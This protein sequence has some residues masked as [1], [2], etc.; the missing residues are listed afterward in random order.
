MWPQVGVGSADGGR[1]QGSPAS[2]STEP[3]AAPAAA[4]AARASAPLGLSAGRAPHRVLWHR[5]RARIRLLYRVRLL[6]AW[7]GDGGVGVAARR[8]DDALGLLRAHAR[9][10]A[11]GAVSNPPSRRQ[12]RR[13]RSP[14][15]AAATFQVAAALASPAARQRTAWT[16]CCRA[17]STMVAPVQTAADTSARAARERGVR[18]C[19]AMQPPRSHRAHDPPHAR[20]SVYAMKACVGVRRREKA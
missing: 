14:W 5:R 12:Q 9:A 6:D 1:A 10:H 3:A 2:R 4:P 17:P 18:L 16:S 11:L 20:S 19:D 7:L 13:L 8:R 15:A